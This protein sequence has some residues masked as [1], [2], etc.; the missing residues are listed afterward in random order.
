MESKRLEHIDQLARE[1]LEKM[2]VPHQAA[3][4]A[5]MEAR[6]DKDAFLKT[7]LYWLKGGELLLMLLALWLLLQFS[8]WQ[9][10]G[11]NFN[12]PDNSTAPTI[13]QSTTPQPQIQPAVPS[14]II[15][16]EQEHTDKKENTRKVEDVPYA[17]SKHKN[18]KNSPLKNVF[19]E[20]RATHI[21]NA[22]NLPSYS[23]Q[24]RAGQSIFETSSVIQTPAFLTPQSDDNYST[25]NTPQNTN[26]S[27]ATTQ[28]YTGST[29]YLP[30]NLTLLDQ[31]MADDL[32]PTD[33]VSPG[34]P[35][36]SRI[37]QPRHLRIAA[38]P[39]MNM[40]SGGY[41]MGMTAS[42]LVGVELTD[43]WK[44]ES[45]LAYS[46]KIF[47]DL[48]MNEEQYPNLNDN[49]TKNMDWHVA[50][51]PLH[52]Q[53]T[54][55]Q[56]T[57]WR[58]FVNVGATAHAVLL[59]D[60][61]YQDGLDPLDSVFDTNREAGLLQGGSLADNVYYTADIGLGLERQLDKNLHLFIQPTYKY[62]LN[63]VGVHRDRVHTFSLVMGA[64][65]A[66]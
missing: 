59:A 22:V 11:I 51:I 9:M 56:S 34:D 36:P 21:A 64:R 55:K 61:G 7:R 2:E 23:S 35:V 45:G 62:A 63:Q 5:A 16:T 27:L 42:G 17:N 60:Y 29:D 31:S 44:V 25:K 10:P 20:N 40:T 1:A 43:K 12:S 24:T 46:A 33:P 47:K 37:R 65:T 8:G 38:S 48:P 58:P 66:L 28:R 15:P 57:N 14:N 52:L 30:M 19:A 3:D 54:I 6:I 41:R 26:T 4:W 13:Q 32:F 39:D 53:Y 50:E 49:Y 18:Q